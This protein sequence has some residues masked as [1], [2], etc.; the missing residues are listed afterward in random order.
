MISRCQDIDMVMVEILY[1][2]PRYPE[3]GSGILAVGNDKVDLT[4][5]D[6]LRYKLPYCQTSGLT[7]NVSDK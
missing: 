2:I 4:V 5:P 6:Q 7:D 1:D 3:T